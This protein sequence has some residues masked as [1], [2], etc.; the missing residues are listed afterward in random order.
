MKFYYATIIFLSFLNCEK[1]QSNKTTI[2]NSVNDTIAINNYFS[3]SLKY[4]DLYSYSKMLKIDFS[5]LKTNEVDS[6][7]KVMYIWDQKYRGDTIH[8]LNTGKFIDAEKTMK[9]LNKRK[10]VDS[11]NYVLLRNITNRFGWPNNEQFSLNAINGAF[12]TILHMNGKNGEN[13]N[14]F[15]FVL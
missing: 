8:N 12:Y 11:I 9:L 14:V 1:N 4:D 6:I 15:L 5:T 10:K 13:S 7:L 2:V 3:F